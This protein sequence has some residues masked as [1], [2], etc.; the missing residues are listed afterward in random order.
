MQRRDKNQRGKRKI[1]ILC[2]CQE[3]NIIHFLFFFM[4]ESR[5]AILSVT[6]MYFIIK[7][8]AAIMTC[9]TVLGLAALYT[10]QVPN[11]S[12]HTFT[13]QGWFE[14]LKLQCYPFQTK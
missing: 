1:N 13:F 2:I 8:H 9:A 6:S 12:I 7:H 11:K 14:I 5:H 3:E 4:G 10:Y